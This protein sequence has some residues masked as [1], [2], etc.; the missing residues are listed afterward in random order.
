MST[1]DPIDQLI[2]SGISVRVLLPY[3]LL[4]VEW[5]AA[6]RNETFKLCYYDAAGAVAVDTAK[7]AAALLSR[8]SELG[9]TPADLDPEYASDPESAPTMFEEAIYDHLHGVHWFASAVDEDLCVPLGW[10]EKHLA[11][12]RRRYEARI[13]KARREARQRE[14]Q[15][16]RE[17]EQRIK[18]RDAKH[19][20]Y[21]RAMLAMLTERWLIAAEIVDQPMTVREAR[22]RAKDK[23]RNCNDEEYEQH[24]AG[25]KM[26]QARHAQADA[27]AG[28]P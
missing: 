28:D 18:D 26:L 3:R 15:A 7:G 5:L 20:P 2:A 22:Q 17:K 21:L 25:V 27:P 24:V 1:I 8:A 11:V 10:P 13:A 19:A 6:N 14:R 12:A 23:L 9:W 4:S 16:K